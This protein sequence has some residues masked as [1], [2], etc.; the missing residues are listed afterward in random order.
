M[1][2]KL[3]VVTVGALALMACSSSPETPDAETASTGSTQQA[4]CEPAKAMPG[5]WQPAEV[6]PEAK[7]AAVLATAS[8]DG[9]HSLKEIH[10]VEQ[11]VVAGM[12]YKVNF[13]IEDGEAY[14]TVV[15]RSLKGEYKLISVQPQA[16]VDECNKSE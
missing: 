5:S 1:Y 9:G 12:N 16:L 4:I 7:Q 14:S 15:F 2:K 3:L 8:M 13:T 10:S 11:Q 6:T